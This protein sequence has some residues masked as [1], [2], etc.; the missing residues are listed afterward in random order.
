MRKLTQLKRAGTPR[1]DGRSGTSLKLVRSK[2]NCVELLQKVRN[3]RQNLRML[4]VE[5]VGPLRSP[6]V[7]LHPRAW[8]EEGGPMRGAER[9]GRADPAQALSRW[10]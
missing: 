7:R 5:L 4:P 3:H 2:K 1:K 10:F 6:G 8:R 9:L